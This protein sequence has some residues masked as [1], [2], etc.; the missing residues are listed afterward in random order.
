[1]KRFKIA[2]NALLLSMGFLAYACTPNGDENSTDQ[3]FIEGEGIIDSTKIPNFDSSE[4]KV[5]T[6]TSRASIHIFEERLNFHPRK[7]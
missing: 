1:M 3:D 7:C 5:D 2:L 4:F 6:A